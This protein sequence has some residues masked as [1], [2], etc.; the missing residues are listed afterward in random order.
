MSIRITKVIY[1]RLRSINNKEMNLEV[2][3]MYTTNE[4]FYKVAL[5]LGSYSK[6]LSFSLYFKPF[7]YLIHLINSLP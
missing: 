2:L 3:E 6:N 1:M 7:N 4:G 5:F